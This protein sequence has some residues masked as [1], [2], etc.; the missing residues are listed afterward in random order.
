[1]LLSKKTCLFLFTGIIFFSCQ[2]REQA[3]T[4]VEVAR[5][6]KLWTGVAVSET[7]R[8]FVNYPRWSP[9]T[10]V[11]VAEIIAPD[12]TIPYPDSE[13]NIWEPSLQPAEHLICVQSVYV[14]RDNYL[15][16]LDP[17]NPLFQGVVSGGAKLLKID[18]ST[19]QVI[20]KII[21]DDQA[22]PAGSYLN[23]IRIDTDRQ[24][25]YIT[26]SG[27]GAIVVVNLTTGEATRRLAIHPSTKA[28]DITLNIEGQQLKIKVHSDGLALDPP[29]KF[30]Y[31]QALTGRSLYRIATDHL[32]NLSLTENEL[33]QK[34]DFVIKSGA[35][36]AIE[37]DQQG[38][39]Y[40][41]SLEFNAIRQYTPQGKIETVVQDGQLKWPDSFAITEG[42]IV[43]VTTSQLH[44]GN[45]RTEPYK[46][47]R[48][49]PD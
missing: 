18:L 44:L 19:N 4:L 20:Q 41:T 29:G 16:I 24:Y 9:E 45:S 35:S 10:A 5:S 38:N 6:E 30:L 48:L 47:F 36:D 34:V 43:Y 11:S 26:D 14:D 21:F 31:Y 13:W 28:E 25:G 33:G 22:A 32:R 39:L 2:S 3:V 12:S 40:L 1:M 27:E 23:D 8:I 17:A 37:F 46:I 42:G 15:W 49:T 7:G